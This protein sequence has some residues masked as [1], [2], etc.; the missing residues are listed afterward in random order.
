MAADAFGEVTTQ[1]ELLGLYWSKR[2]T[3]H[4]AAEVCLRKAVTQMVDTLG[5]RADRL[6]LAE[7]N[8]SGLQ[9]LLEESVLVQISRNRYV[10]FRHHILSDYAA[11]RVY[12]NLANAEHS[13]KLF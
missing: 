11:S 10:A 1:A 9:S 5:L 7:I 2:V 3:K 8:V 13:A 12:L 6:T 4:P